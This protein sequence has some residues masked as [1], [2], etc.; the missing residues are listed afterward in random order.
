MLAYGQIPSRAMPLNSFPQ[1][2]KV[3]IYATGVSFSITMAGR[4]KA[5]R[6]LVI[7]TLPWGALFQFSDGT[8]AAKE[9]AE[10]P[11]Q[12]PLVAIG[13]RF[14]AKGGFEQLDGE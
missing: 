8:L 7:D 5:Q 2:A 13:D 3:G 10:V 9:F 4:V 14:K 6:F 12:S 11:T 1:G